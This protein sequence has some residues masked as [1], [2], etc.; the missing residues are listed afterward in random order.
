MTRAAA[1][2][3][4]PP[5]LRRVA[6]CAVLLTLIVVIFGAY[7][8]I[9]DAGLACPDWPG[10]YGRLWVPDETEAARVQKSHPL[11]PLDR[12]RA[13]KELLHRYLAAALGLLI[14]FMT[15]LAVLQ[16][17]R[18]GRLL[19]LPP[20]LCLLILGQAQLGRLT[21]TLLLEPLVVTA[22]LL[23]GALILLLLWWF[24]LSLEA[25]PAAAPAPV[26]RGL[27]APACLALL[28]LFGQ[29]ALGGWTSAHYAG[30]A[31]PDF[32][33]CEGQWWPTHLDFRGAFS[34]RERVATAAAPSPAAL[35]TIQIAHRA[36]GLLILLLL[37]SL[38]VRAWLVGSPHLRR[39]S[40]TLGLLLCLQFGIGVL[41]VWMRLPTPLATAH[42]AGAM[43][44]LMAMGLFLHRTRAGP[45]APG[46]APPAPFPRTH[47]RPLR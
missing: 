46:P 12:E 8:R 19:W 44:L 42:N 28:L 7:V 20:L 40:L 30:M 17:R 5:R 15:L 34:F 2:P 16:R 41:A 25:R 18:L 4:P 39:A 43:L 47:A 6:G 45:S 33:T 21:V 26:D 37:G 24:F 27:W 32:P 1:H 36:G 11:Q 10:C 23:G 35:Q 22:H 38:A 13:G 9:S 31:C 14:L 29:L 3:G